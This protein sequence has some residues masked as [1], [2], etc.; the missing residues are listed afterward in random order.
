MID[1]NLMRYNTTL[2]QITV[3]QLDR[4]VF[5][6]ICL[7][8]ALA[9]T[10]ALPSDDRVE[11]ESYYQDNTRYNLQTLVEKINESILG[12]DVDVVL[13]TSRAFWM[14]RYN[15]A[16]PTRFMSMTARSVSFT[17]LL[18]QADT[19][20]KSVHRKMLDENQAISIHLINIFTD[21]ILELSPPLRERT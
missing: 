21:V 3:G 14:L 17:D 1:T 16:F 6:S 12:L 11:P 10:L 20:V 4:R 5:Q 8:V 9:R 7:G 18:L 15:A 13:E 2:N 19:F